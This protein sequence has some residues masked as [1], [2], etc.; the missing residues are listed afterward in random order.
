MWGTC[1][2]LEGRTAVVWAVAQT[3]AVFSPRWEKPIS[4]KQVPWQVGFVG[5][6]RSLFPCETLRQHSQ[7]TH[8]K[9]VEREC[10]LLYGANCLGAVHL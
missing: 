4:F 10:A 2:S 1:P 5:V 6:G 8:P 9:H 7:S 3:F